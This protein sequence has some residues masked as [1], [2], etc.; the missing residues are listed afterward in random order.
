[1]KVPIARAVIADTAA[2]L[3]HLDAIEAD[4]RS[5]GRITVLERVSRDALSVDVEFGVASE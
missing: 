5:A 2:N 1:M 4:L 3:A